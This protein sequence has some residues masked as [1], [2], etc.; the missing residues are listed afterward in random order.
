MKMR[1]RK[2]YALYLN[3]VKGY[4]FSYNRLIFIV[5]QNV[6]V[7]IVFLENKWL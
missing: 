3:S 7:V 5:C 4:F 2:V 6:C 1:E